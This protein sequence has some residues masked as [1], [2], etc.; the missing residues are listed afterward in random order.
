MN[1]VISETS[2]VVNGATLTVFGC[3]AGAIAALSGYRMLG[4][5]I[6]LAM[7]GLGCIVSNRGSNMKIT[8]SSPFGGGP[9]GGQHVPSGD[10][11]RN[12]YVSDRTTADI[13]PRYERM[14]ESANN[15]SAELFRIIR[16]A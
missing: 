12:E 3:A 4:A 14:D 5:T 9:N 16:N 15:G 7:G 2:D 8:L 6:A 13:R 1:H 10:E 11:G